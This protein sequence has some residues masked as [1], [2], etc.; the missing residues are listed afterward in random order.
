MM[1]LTVITLSAVLYT[2]A[3]QHQW[4]VL[5]L[6]LVCV[7]TWGFAGSIPPSMHVMFIGVFVATWQLLRKPTG[8]THEKSNHPA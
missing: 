8:V 3:K 4:G 7:A 6:L 1:I 5:V 2:A